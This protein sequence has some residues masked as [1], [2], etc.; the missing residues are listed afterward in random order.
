MERYTAAQLRSMPTLATGQADDLKV[1]R[2]HTRVWLSRCTVADGEP[3]NNKVTVERQGA[4][5]RWEVRDV[6]Q[7]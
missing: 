2:A 4:L 7:G 1:E 5:G 3:F 6:Y